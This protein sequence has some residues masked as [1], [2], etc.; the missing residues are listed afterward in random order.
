MNSLFIRKPRRLACPS[1][2]GVPGRSNLGS[3]MAAS[4]GRRARRRRV[5]VVVEPL[6]QL[7]GVRAGLGAPA[8]APA[9]H[10]AVVLAE[11]DPQ[12]PAVLGG[13]HL[14]SCGWVASGS[15]VTSSQ[16]A[17]GSDIRAS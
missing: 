14:R 5:L 2:T 9:H 10:L 13:R 11:G 7:P 6:P 16:G 12:L 15:T 1:K 17:I 8:P 4:R 3:V